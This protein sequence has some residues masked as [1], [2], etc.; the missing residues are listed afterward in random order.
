[1]ATGVDVMLDPMGWWRLHIPG[2]QNGGNFCNKALTSAGIESGLFCKEGEG[3][4][5]TGFP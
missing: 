4:T 2:A 1:V 5:E 3:L